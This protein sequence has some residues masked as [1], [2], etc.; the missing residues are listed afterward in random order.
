LRLVA[1]L[2]RALEPSSQDLDR[3]RDEAASS[4]RYHDSGKSRSRSLQTCHQLTARRNK[5]SLGN[6]LLPRRIGLG[7][8][9]FAAPLRL[10]C[11]AD[12]NP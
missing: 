8:L 2:L 5:K 12:T 10:D 9:V 11:P 7:R 3:Y 1:A 6:R 4:A